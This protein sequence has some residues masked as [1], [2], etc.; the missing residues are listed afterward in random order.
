V[1]RNIFLIVFSVFFVGCNF[2]VANFESF[3]L[4][5]EKKINTQDFCT[6]F[7]YILNDNSKEYG[8]LFVEYI[9]LDISCNWNG[10]ARGYFDD[11]FSSTLKLKSMKTIE[12][13]DYGNYEFSTYLINDKYYM[14]LIYKFS[15]TENLFVIDYDGKL[16][17][18]LIKEFDVNY[19]N[20]YKDMLRF[21]SN[22]STSLVNKNIINSYFSRESESS[23]SFLNE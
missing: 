19:V 4:N 7:S 5:K 10:F 14:N 15:V 17:E 18:K 3:P 6:N 21:E 1:I 23:N 9:D 20:K 2:K 16:S 12:R 11:L 13:L 22:Y 8:K